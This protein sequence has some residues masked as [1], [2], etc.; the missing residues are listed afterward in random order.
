MHIFVV[1]SIYTN[2]HTVTAALEIAGKLLFDD[3]LAS[4]MRP[5]KYWTL[6]KDSLS[7]SLD[8]V[9]QLLNFF[10]IESQRILFAENI[11]ATVAVSRTLLL[12]VPF[13]SIGD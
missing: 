10:I 13:S 9:E 2:C 7:A 8:D 6:S 4:K 11:Y 5:R 3:G 1:I 12:L